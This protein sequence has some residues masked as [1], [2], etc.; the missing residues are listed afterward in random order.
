MLYYLAKNGDLLYKPVEES[1]SILEEQD[2]GQ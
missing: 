1:L 2:I